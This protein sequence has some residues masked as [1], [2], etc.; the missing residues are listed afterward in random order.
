[1]KKIKKNFRVENKINHKALKQI[2]YTGYFSIIVIYRGLYN[3][4]FV[5]FI[6]SLHLMFFFNNFLLTKK[7][8]MIMNILFLSAFFYVNF[9]YLGIKSIY[10]NKSM[11]NIQCIGDYSNPHFLTSYI[12]GSFLLYLYDYMIN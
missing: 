12:F 11:R 1:M 3:P 2:F 9:H 8:G 4:L 10:L 7:I 5:I 6:F